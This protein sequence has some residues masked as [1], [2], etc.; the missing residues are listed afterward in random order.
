M[1]I[2]FGGATAHATLTSGKVT[3]VTVD[4]AGM[5]YSIPPKVIFIG[6]G[7]TG[8]NMQNSTFLGGNQ[9]GYPAPAHPAAA[10]C[11]MTGVVG[12]QTVSSIV[13]D[14]PGV[15][16]AIAPKVFLQNDPND[17]YGAFAPSTGGIGCILLPANG[18]VPYIRNGTTCF[19]DQVSII[20]ASSSKN[21]TC[22]YMV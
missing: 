8:W 18:T 21:F 13:I 16:Y 10:H 3:S 7:N 19:V 2:G 22:K 17:P 5:L 9:T 4:N 14:D 15:G 1:Y 20:C 6:G 12:A 11:V